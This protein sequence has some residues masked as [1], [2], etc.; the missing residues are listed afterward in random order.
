M[1][2]T[3]DTK[4]MTDEGRQPTDDGQR[5]HVSIWYKDVR[6]LFDIQLTVIDFI[7]SFNFDRYLPGSWSEG[8][9]RFDYRISI[10]DVVK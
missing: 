5:Q 4:R 7:L 2:D 3:E 6:W 8:L 9:L 10:W 1:V